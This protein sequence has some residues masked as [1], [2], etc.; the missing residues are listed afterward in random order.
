MANNAQAKNEQ[1]TI[2]PEKLTLKGKVHAE[3]YNR[4]KA[5]RLQH[6]VEIEK[7]DVLLNYYNGTI[8]AEAKKFEEENKEKK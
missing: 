4:L 6:E 7:I 5:Q 8:S 3:Q 2:D 1:I